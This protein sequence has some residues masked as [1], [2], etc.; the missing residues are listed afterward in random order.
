MTVKKECASWEAIGRLM[1]DTAS[2]VSVNLT[3]IDA[4]ISQFK[5]VL[6]EMEFKPAEL[7]LHSCFNLNITVE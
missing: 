5:E 6:L 7:V 1:T 2:S 4:V 3:K